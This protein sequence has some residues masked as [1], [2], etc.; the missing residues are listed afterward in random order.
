MCA[1]YY[2]IRV[3]VGRT[4]TLITS[5]YAYA[6]AAA[7]AA[8]SILNSNAPRRVYHMCICVRYFINTT[9]RLF[10]VYLLLDVETYSLFVS[11]RGNVRA[12]NYTGFLP[13]NFLKFNFFVFQS[14]RRLNRRWEP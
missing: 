8:V 11:T 9:A 5:N 2:C 10:D 6:T 12:I 13:V 7:A 14:E 1:P 3:R 4:I